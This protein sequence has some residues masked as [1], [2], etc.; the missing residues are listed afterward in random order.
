MWVE[1]GQAS[2]AGNQYVAKVKHFSTINADLVKTNQACVRID[3]PS[4][5]ST[6]SLEATIPMPAR[7][8]R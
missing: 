8:R 4:L 5:P 6:Y 1:E 3:S 7:R 2:L